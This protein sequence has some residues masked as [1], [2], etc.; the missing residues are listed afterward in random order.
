MNNMQDAYKSFYKKVNKSAIMK[1]FYNLI[2]WYFIQ[3]YK[4]KKKI[5]RIGG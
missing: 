2:A 1:E 3:N 4:K 5:Y